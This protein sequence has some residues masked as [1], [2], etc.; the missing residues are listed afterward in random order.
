MGLHELRFGNVAKTL[1]VGVT[2]SLFWIYQSLSKLQSKTCPVN[3]FFY[4][5][6]LSWT[7]TNH[8]TAGER[9]GISLY[10]NSHFHP[11]HR[12][13]D[14]SRV[15]TAESSPLH[16]ASSQTRTGRTFGFQAQVASHQAT[17][18]N[19]NTYLSNIKISSYFSF[20][21]LEYYQR[22][23]KQRFPSVSVWCSWE[24]SKI[25]VARLQS[26]GL[27]LKHGS[28]ASIKTTHVTKIRWIVLSLM[29][30]MYMPWYNYGRYFYT[31][32]TGNSFFL[33][34]IMTYKSSFILSMT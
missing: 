10:P 6:F 18:K 4:L 11:F 9:E 19:M 27:R 14:I 28:I 29:C 32:M 8:R 15:I 3:R 16:I 1:D 30:Y 31:V 20:W 22:N 33:H 2:K 25:V 5:G 17:N 34:A 12:H 23:S 7:F 21:K 26:S 13:L 24:S